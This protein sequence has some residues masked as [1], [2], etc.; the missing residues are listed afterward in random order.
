MLLASTALTMLLGSLI[1]LVLVAGRRPHLVAPAWLGAVRSSTRLSPRALAA[2]AEEVADPD[3]VPKPG[4]GELRTVRYRV[5][6]ITDRPQEVHATELARLA[7]GAVVELIQEQGAYHQIRTESGL[8]GWIP[9]VAL[10][11]PDQVEG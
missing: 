3:A 10:E 9:T 11:D 7:G 5:A 2:A 8:E 6:R 1:I 4:T